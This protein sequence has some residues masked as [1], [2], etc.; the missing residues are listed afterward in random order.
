MASWVYDPR[1]HAWNKWQFP[2]AWKLVPLK[3]GLGLWAMQEKDQGWNPG[4]K[5]FTV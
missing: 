3:E 2:G 4:P 5:M 1:Q